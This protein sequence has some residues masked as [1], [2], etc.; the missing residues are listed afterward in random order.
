MRV[1]AQSVDKI[2]TLEKALQEMFRTPGPYVLD[3]H[4]RDEQM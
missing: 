4:V 2:A 3:V 1:P